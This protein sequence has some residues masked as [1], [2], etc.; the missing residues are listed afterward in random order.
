MQN[1][2]LEDIIE[3]KLVNSP[4]QIEDRLNY[5][6]EKIKNNISSGE[7]RFSKLIDEINSRFPPK[8][9]PRGAFDGITAVLFDT[10][11][12]L[13]FIGNN[14]ALFV[15]L[16]GILERFC[17]NE[18]TDLLPVDEKSKKII[19]KSYQRKT[20]RDF[21]P[22]FKTLD[23][24]E[25]DD[26]KFARKLTTIRNG[27]AHK[28]TNLVSRHLHD[29]KQNHP[30]SIHEI[31]ANVDCIPYIL[32]TVDLIIKASKA[33]QPSF[34]DNPRFKARYECYTGII[35]PIYNLLCYREFI[36][37]P[38]D[39]KETAIFDLLGP[40][41]LIS[42]KE[43]SEKLTEFGSQVLRFHENLNKNDKEAKKLYQ[44]LGE[45][46]KNITDL[47][48]KDLKIDGDPSIFKEPNFISIKEIKKRKANN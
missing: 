40:S 31:T 24:W 30:T 28:N 17:F 10:A 23:L 27:I 22:Y 2:E 45:I 19:T 46:V 38:K 26:V 33:A 12:E 1:K 20:L 8:S 15:E 44:S 36:N 9:A 32:N 5:L 34:I 3:K 47:M 7:K 25:E 43:L 16:Q 13:Y 39:V 37:L 42:S 35:A 14:S 48:R 41:M 6:S 29:G 11:L 18:L 4:L 21:A